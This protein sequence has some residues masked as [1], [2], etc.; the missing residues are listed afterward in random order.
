MRIQAYLRSSNKF[1]DLRIH[2]ECWASIYCNGRENWKEH[3]EAVIS[4]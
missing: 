3:H 1:L 4:T 2:Y